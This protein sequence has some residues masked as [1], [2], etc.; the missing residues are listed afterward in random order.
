MCG[1]I[2]RLC[3][4]SLRVETV[5]QNQRQL[6]IN[7]ELTTKKSRYRGSVSRAIERESLVFVGSNH[8]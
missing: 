2:D 6:R 4:L 1:L 5:F 8:G 3:K 7:L